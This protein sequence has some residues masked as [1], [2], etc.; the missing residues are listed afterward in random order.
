LPIAIALH[1]I[2]L[3]SVGVAQVW[4]VAAV[5]DPETVT[6]FQVLLVPSLPAGGSQPPTV[7]TQKPATTA[8]P[9][10]PDT[11]VLPDKPASNPAQEATNGPVADS[12]TT[13]RNDDSDIDLG[14]SDG[15]F[16][17]PGPADGPSSVAPAA[18]TTD[19]QI[20]TVG[21]AVT[22]PVLLSGRPPQFPEIARRAR[23]VGAVVLRAV[24][25]ERG[26]VTDVRVLQGLPMGIDKVAVEAVQ[27]WLFQPARFEGRAVKVYYT[28]TVNFQIQR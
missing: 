25:D 6:P 21:G 26:R 19:D 20:L 16:T 15:P 4:N 28:L 17:G 24:I 10:Q 14:P 7:H 11:R 1:G 13:G 18:A 27:T 12:P 23:I 5:S 22:R 9:A 2:V 8:K 3:A